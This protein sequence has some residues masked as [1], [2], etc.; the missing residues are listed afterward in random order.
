MT[1]DMR[2]DKVPANE[3]LRVYIR[4]TDHVLPS[5]LINRQTSNHQKHSQTSTQSYNTDISVLFRQVLVFLHNL[6]ASIMLF[7]SLFLV[8]LAAASPDPGV[9]QSSWSGM[10]IATFNVYS[11]QKS[12][13]CGGTLSSLPT[14]IFGAAASD[15]SPNISGGPCNASVGDGTCNGQVPNNSSYEGPH[16]GTSNC[17]W[18]YKV[19]NDGSAKWDSVAQGIG[20]SVVVQIIDACPHN[21]AMNYC[22]T[23]Q[24]SNQT[25]TSDSTNQLDIDQNA[26]MT[27]TGEAYVA[28]QTPNLNIMIEPASC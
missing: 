16:C 18:C 3:G 5:N 23:E 14:G 4:E 17:G 25:C 19:T 1:R 2:S 7:A 27:L 6:T 21:S 28:G 22:K 15:I 9:T 10:G 12:L 8:G 24:P 13:N 11:Q 20:N 26:Y